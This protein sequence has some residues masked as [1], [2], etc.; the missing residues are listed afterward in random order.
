[1]SDADRIAELEREVGELRLKIASVPRP[2]APPREDER[3]VTISTPTPLV[4]M[5]TDDELR[6]LLASFASGIRSWGRR[7]AI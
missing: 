2:P 5:P 6:R 7:A 3:Q 1:M 4:V